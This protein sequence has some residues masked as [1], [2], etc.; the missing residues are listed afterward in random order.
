MCHVDICW[1]LQVDITR[2]GQTNPYHDHWIS[3]VYAVTDPAHHEQALSV[4]M[5]T[6]D[7]FYGSIGFV[8]VNE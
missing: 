3:A 8:V 7:E 4:V 1:P 6:K 5:E 2:K